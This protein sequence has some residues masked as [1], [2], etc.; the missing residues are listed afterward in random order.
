[1]IWKFIA[2]R[3]GISAVRNIMEKRSIKVIQDHERRIKLLEKAKRKT[4]KRRK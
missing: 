1:M 4:K 2:K 3:L